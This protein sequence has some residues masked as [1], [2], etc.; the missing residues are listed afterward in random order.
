LHLPASLIC[1][2]KE[3]AISLIVA[4]SLKKDYWYIIFQLVA[5][6]FIGFDVVSDYL[7][8]NLYDMLSHK[9]Y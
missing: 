5:R 4:I 9:N 8:T 1:L 6:I 2:N 3:Q 7:K